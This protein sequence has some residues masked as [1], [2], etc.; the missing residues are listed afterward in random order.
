M[1]LMAADRHGELPSD[2]RIIKKICMLDGPPDIDRFISLGFLEFFDTETGDKMTSTRRQA[3]VKPTPQ[4]RRFVPPTVDQVSEFAGE[5]DIEIDAGRFVDFYASKGW[6]VGKSPMKCWQSAVRNWARRRQEQ[7]TGT[8]R[9]QR[10]QDRET[11]AKILNISSGGG[12]Y[13]IDYTDK[14]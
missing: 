2:P 10:L 6:L 4:K 11:M 7:K 8:P 1:W 5:Q 9:D 14:I 13:E 3:D 12:G